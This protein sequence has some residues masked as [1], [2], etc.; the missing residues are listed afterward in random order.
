MLN[1][2]FRPKWQHADPKVRLTF[3]EGISP[4]NKT[5][6]S[7]IIS[8]DKSAEVRL[9][10]FTKSG[11]FQARLE[12][13]NNPPIESDKAAFTKA[14]IT[15]LDEQHRVQSL[16]HETISQL[17]Q[18]EL[19]D[20]FVEHS[21][22]AALIEQ[23]I[24]QTDD[25]A[26]CLKYLKGS[27][28]HAIR[29]KLALR[30]QS[31]EALKS[32]YQWTKSKDKTIAKLLKQKLDIIQ[33]AHKN[34]KAEILAATNLLD[35]LDIIK[36]GSLTTPLEAEWLA[37]KNKFNAINPSALPAAL[38]SSLEAS[39][40]EIKTT[41][42]QHEQN[43]QSSQQAAVQ[44]ALAANTIKDFEA[45]I[46]QISVQ[47]EDTTTAA[48][49]IEASFEQLIDALST[50]S[51][52]NNEDRL[53]IQARIDEL[54]AQ[55]T[56][57]NRLKNQLESVQSETID[58]SLAEKRQSAINHLVSKLPVSSQWVQKAKDVVISLN[59]HI[60]DS[61]KQQKEQVKALKIEVNSTEIAIEEKQLS[62]AQKHLSQARKTFKQLNS[63]EQ[64]TWRATLKRL[65]SG[66]KALTDWRKFSTDPIRQAMLTKMDN[67][68]AIDMDAR[69]KNQTI[70]NLQK[71]WRALGHTEDKK[72]WDDFQSLANKAYEPC[73][74]AFEKEKSQRIFNAQQRE[75]ICIETE[76]FI[77]QCDW[78]R[79]DY[80][81]LNKLLKTMHTEWR[82]FSPVERSAHLALQERFSSSTHVI[83]ERLQAHKKENLEQLEA[84]NARAQILLAQ[85]DIAQAIDGYKTLMTEWKQ[86]GITFREK[87]TEQWE[88]FRGNGDQIYAKLKAA[89]QSDKAAESNQINA[90]ND[91]LENIRQLTKT[92]QNNAV[93]TDTIS[94]DFNKLCQNFEGPDTLPAKAQ[95]SLRKA[96]TQAC[97]SFEEAL[98]QNQDIQWTNQLQ[99]FDQYAEALNTQIENAYSDAFN[100]LAPE[101]RD[102]IIRRRESWQN[103]PSAHTV[104]FAKNCCIDLEILCEKPSPDSDANARINRQIQSL[105]D[106]FGSQQSTVDKKPLIESLYIQWFGQPESFLIANSDLTSRFLHCLS[107]SGSMKETTAST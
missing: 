53:Q 42:D 93:N 33:S 100:H 18:H 3:V 23:I 95:A 58:A 29:H 92:L 55:H 46:V 90:Y 107:S 16:K 38:L 22:N 14:L 41:L 59:K 76:Q 47:L 68:A 83:K 43:R 72:L 6:I 77:A 105:K 35:K 4:D 19:L 45:A 39:L 101:W 86:V 56:L 13:V 75:K 69:A 8:T 91:V 64:G 10:A 99:R 61:K 96:F 9:R 106:N 30:L 37:A 7:T 31:E 28:N 51:T 89:K 11:S 65:E 80:K 71:E 21:T 54:Q 32:A 15:F 85:E 87:Q 17:K 97:K 66:V 81:A 2:F 12:W 25:E 78:G 26:Q 50:N 57:I 34:Q 36:K 73:K 88:N 103:Q 44:Q 74:Q 62:A 20:T 104:D 102:A 52:I 27:K 48:A 49:S 98:T 1:K 5:L 79:T 94:A 84:I 67:L 40:A 82:R 63:Q 70:K 60:L 24:S